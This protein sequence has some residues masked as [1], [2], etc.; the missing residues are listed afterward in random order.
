MGIHAKVR[1]L[2]C[3]TFPPQSSSLSNSFSMVNLLKL[4]FVWCMFELKFI[5]GV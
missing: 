1:R 2:N 3:T 4:L 5:Y